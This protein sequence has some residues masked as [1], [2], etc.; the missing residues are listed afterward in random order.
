M[1]PEGRIKQGIKALLR[2]YGDQ[3]Y[4]DM[5]VPCGFGKSG[6]DFEGAINGHA[7]SIEAKKPGGKTTPRQNRTIEGKRRAGVAVFVID[8]LSTGEIHVLVQWLNEVAV[9]TEQKPPQPSS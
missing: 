3:L 9:R 7:F 8:N 5:P 1:T 2:H 4:Y 6:L